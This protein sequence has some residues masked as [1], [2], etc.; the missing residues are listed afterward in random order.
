M[1]DIDLFGDGS[2]RI[3]STPGH[4]PGEVSL[5]VRLPDRNV[6]LTGDTVH[7]REALERELTFSADVDTVSARRSLS[8]LKLVSAAYDA[9]VWIAH[10]ED[11]WK[12]HG[13][14][15]TAYT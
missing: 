5:L 7:I 4:T 2:V 8:R 3:L 6:I 10:D 11:D 15:P 13:E 9:A 1:E 12:S 14:L